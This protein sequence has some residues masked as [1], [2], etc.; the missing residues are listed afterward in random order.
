MGDWFDLQD[1]SVA[2]K[3]AYDCAT[4]TYNNQLLGDW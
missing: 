4:F 3:F 2:N 1:V